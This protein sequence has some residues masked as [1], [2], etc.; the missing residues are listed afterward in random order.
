MPTRNNRVFH[1]IVETADGELPAK[2]KHF[3][4]VRFVRHNG[5]KDCLDNENMLSIDKRTPLI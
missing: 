3:D 1:V 4:A 5:V 2:S